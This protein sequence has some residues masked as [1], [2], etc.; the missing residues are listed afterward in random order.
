[1]KQ[2]LLSADG[3]A[4][5]CDAYQRFFINVGYGVETAGDGLDCLEKLR[6]L[7]QAALVLDLERRRRAGLGARGECLAHGPRRALRRRRLPA[8]PR[9][10][11]RAAPS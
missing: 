11:H 8:R 10:L 2:S 1:M 6:R 4:G 7:V 5:L 9:R 3:D